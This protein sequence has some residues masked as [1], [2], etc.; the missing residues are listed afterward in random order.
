[1]TQSEILLHRQGA[2]A[3]ITLHRPK[4]LNA[5]TMAMI[6]DLTR[7]LH[8]LSHDDSVAAVVFE[9]AGGRAYCAGGDIRA[10]HDDL[11]SRG[12]FHET[13]WRQEYALNALIARYPKPCVPLMDGIV[14]GG[15][16][17]ISAHAS[18]RVVTERTRL[19]M[20]EV[21]LGFIPDVGA[22]WLLSRSPGELGTFL[23]LTGD[24][25][26]AADAITCGLAD[27]LVPSADL[28]RLAEALT[29][30]P[31][32]GN[33]T[34][35]VT[36]IIAGFARDPGPS[37]LAD[38]RAAIDEAFAHDSVEPILGAAAA[39]TDPFLVE[40]ARRIATRSP[41]ALKVTLAMLRRARHLD[42]VEDCLALEFRI[43]DRLAS[44][45][46]FQEGIR[47]VVV[48][49]DGAPRWNPASLAAV[50]DA[51]VARYFAPLDKPELWHT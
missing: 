29:C 43:G 14:M 45:G 48:D 37:P 47:A 25:I 24:T 39:S 18:H 51:D 21:G 12:G 32:E 50:A 31:A 10:L 7:H 35:G 20:P 5:L 15:G 38:H 28:P 42:T 36:R 8:E 26:A 19:A 27:Y 49:K 4:A 22:S 41:L 46:D 44:A 17:G 1:M 3:R 6:R 23:A 30:L 9:G 34:E 33:A 40:A 2:I 13:F 16:V 11:V